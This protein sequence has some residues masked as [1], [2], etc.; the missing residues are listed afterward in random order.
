MVRESEVFIRDKTKVASRVSIVISE[1]VLILASC[2]G[3]PTMG[4]KTLA[5]MEEDTHDVVHRAYFVVRDVYVDVFS[6][7]FTK[8]LTLRDFNFRQAVLL[9]GFAERLC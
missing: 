7:D 2:C 9:S 4:V 8:A 6:F 5:V 3:R 1:L